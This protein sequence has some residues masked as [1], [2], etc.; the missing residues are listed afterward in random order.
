MSM[1]FVVKWGPI[2]RIMGALMMRPMMKKV[3]KRILRGLAYH[4]ATGDTVNKE[5]PAQNNLNLILSQ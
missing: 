4:S 3:L 1:D 2:G 5:L